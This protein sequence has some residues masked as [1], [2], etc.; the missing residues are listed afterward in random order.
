M[1]ENKPSEPGPFGKFLNRFTD[2]SVDPFDT[3]GAQFFERLIPGMRKEHANRYIFAVQKLKEMNMSKPLVIDAATGHGYGAKIIK[4]A[5]PEA[6]FLGF[7][8][9]PKT[10]AEANRKYGSYGTYLR[11]DVRQLPV[12]DAKADLVTA[13][14][15]LEHLPPEDQP[16]FLRELRRITKPDGQII[17]SVPYPSST[18]RGKDNKIRH[19]FGS[20]YH[21]Y[22][23]TVHEMKHMIE[24]SGLKILGEYG[25]ALAYSN[26][27]KAVSYLNRVVP[28]W[29]LYSWFPIF[30]RDHT[31]QP[32]PD[33]PHITS[34]IHVFVAQPKA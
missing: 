33:K 6:T 22:E 11:A 14:E 21:L 28:I 16:K 9:N 24:S 13:F 10:L 30:R 31:V 18:F 27:A 26:R 12:D 23:P 25:Q 32:M 1:V 7:D 17:I 4:E 2:E 8:L 19:G 3:S 20:G 34:L 29:G 5:V 15:T